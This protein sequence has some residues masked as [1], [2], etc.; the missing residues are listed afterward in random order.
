MGDGTSVAKSL[1]RIERTVVVEEVESAGFV[2]E[3]EA[4]FLRNE[5]DA[6]DW[7]ASPSQVGSRRGASDR[8]VLKF[9]K[10][11]EGGVTAPR[12][13]PPAQTQTEERGEDFTACEEP[14]SPMCTK[15]YHP[16]CASVDTGVRCVTTPCPSMTKKTYGNA[17]TACA[18]AK[19]A[20]YVPGACPTEVG[21]AK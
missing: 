18:D 9:R 7:D 6:R 13:P 21:K 2:L 15:E 1:H 5:G 16:V 17:C 19:V 10:P 12:V 20:G 8:F 14:R 3:A 4:E 11:E